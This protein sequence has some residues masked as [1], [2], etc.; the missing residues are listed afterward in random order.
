DSRV[1]RASE[2]ENPELFWGL[3]GGGGN[4]GVVTSFEYRLHQIGPMINLGLF[5]WSADRTVEALRLRARIG[6]MVP[7][8]MGVFLGGLNMPPA[9]FVPETLHFTP[10]VAAVAV[11]WGSPEEPAAAVAR[12]RDAL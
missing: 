8:D 4:F 5:L 2:S 7:D 9:P 3:R 12:I 11:G 10:A 1:V 6:R